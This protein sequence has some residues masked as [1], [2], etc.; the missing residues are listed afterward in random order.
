MA[1]LISEAGDFVK[2]I[3]ILSVCIAAAI[4]GLV[5]RLF[6][7]AVADG[8][9]LAEEAVAQR[10]ESVVFESPR[11]IIYDRNMIK[12]TNAEMELVYSGETPYYID[13]RNSS[14][15]SHVIGYISPGGRGS[16][17]EGAFDYVLA[18]SEKAHISYLKDINNNRTSDGYAVDVEKS[19]AGVALTIDCHIQKI[20]EDAMDKYGIKGAAVVAECESGEIAA[21]ASR[22]N[23]DRNNLAGFLNGTDGELVNKAI[24]AYNPG[25]VFKIAVAAAALEGAADETARFFCGGK[26]DI[27]GMDFVCHKNG[28]HG[29]QDMRTAFANSCNC[30]FYEIGRQTGIEKIHAVASGFG[31]GSE[32]LRINGI[33][34]DIGNVPRTVTSN[35]ELAN[36]S[37]GQGDVMITPLQAADML[38]T[39]CSGGVRKQLTLVKGMVDADGNCQSVSGGEVGRVISETTARKLVD[40]M[41][42]AVKNGTGKSADI[43][44]YGSG[45]K[46]GSAE[47][48]WKK[49]GELMQQGWF[50]GFFPAENPK[51]VCVVV[52]ENGKSGS[53]SACP[54]FAE[55]GTG[56]CKLMN[57]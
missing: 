48:G 25:S 41:K 3:K 34:E 9:T 6:Y 55:I 12:L 7:I 40:M 50:A 53:D 38:C 14:L 2:R 51:Y 52:A 22:P 35:A 26:S 36:I 23:F 43:E 10:T 31:I 11:G 28:G 5:C 56:V 37:I 27:D 24:R 46:T 17:I 4:S 18:P 30:A 16:G 57:F 20:T 15:L 39:I 21:M 33:A 32:V 29:N 42:Y 54:V 19:Y 45:G 47:T 1:I 49:D 13:R 44:K 8:K